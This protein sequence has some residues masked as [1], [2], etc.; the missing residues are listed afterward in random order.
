MCQTASK[1]LGG[2]SLNDFRHSEI[3]VMGWEY[4]DAQLE[5]EKINES[6]REIIQGMAGGHAVHQADALKFGLYRARQQNG[7]ANCSFARLRCID[8]ACEARCQPVSPFS[9]GDGIK[10]T[11]RAGWFGTM[12]NL[13]MVC[14]DCGHA[15]IDHCSWCKGCRSMFG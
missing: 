8:R 7:A 5:T 12:C 2:L 1:S 6:I 3:V 9:P 11:K 13:T 4:M 10:C 14:S 15:R